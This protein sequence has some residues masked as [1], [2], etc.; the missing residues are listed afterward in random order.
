MREAADGRLVAGHRVHLVTTTTL[1]RDRY[2]TAVTIHT[3]VTTHG[4]GFAHEGL[5][6]VGYR[7][8][9]A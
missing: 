9:L 2:S 4:T 6:I 5:Y 1:P 3:P 7:R 8:V